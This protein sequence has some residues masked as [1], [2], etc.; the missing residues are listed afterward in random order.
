[1]ENQN[2]NY[3]LV[4]SNGC[5]YVFSQIKTYNPIFLK[6]KLPPN[7]NFRFIED[8]L[9]TYSE[10]ELDFLCYGEKQTLAVLPQS[11]TWQDQQ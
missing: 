5:F 2:Q 10:A 6:N 7:N 9:K 1:M 8:S 11:F 4:T 3:F